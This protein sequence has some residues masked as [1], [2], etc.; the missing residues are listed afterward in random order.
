MAATISTF[1]QA[2]AA[3]N[4]AIHLGSAGAVVGNLRTV[5]AALQAM[6]AGESNGAG[7]DR[8]QSIVAG[9]GPKA[10]AANTAGDGGGVCVSS[11]AAGPAL[12]SLHSNAVAAVH[13]EPTLAV[14]AM[15]DGTIGLRVVTKGFLAHIG[16][17]FDG[18]ADPQARFDADRDQHE[19]CR[20]HRS[21]RQRCARRSR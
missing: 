1:A 6:V 12:R 17:L 3:F 9:L 21:R 8:I 15:V 7:F 14:L 13:A 2:G 18:V 11:A 10:I 4:D 16:T 5:Q 19:H 20:H